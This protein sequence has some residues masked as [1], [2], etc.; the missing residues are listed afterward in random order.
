M[1][2]PRSSPGIEAAIAAFNQ[3][4]V[5]RQLITPYAVLT[6]ETLPGLYQ[7]G[8]SG[9]QIRREVIDQ[10]LEIPL[11]IG[12][13]RSQLPENRPRCIG[14][15]VPFSEHEW[16]QNLVKTM[17]A[18]SS[19]LGIEFEIIDVHQS[20]RDEIEMRRKEI[21]ACAA[22]LINP[23]DVILI[24]SGPLATFLAE[25]LREKENI[26]VITN[27]IDVFDVLRANSEIILILT[28]GAYRHTS[29]ALVGP[30][31]EGALRELRADKLFLS[32]AGVSLDFGLSHTNISEVTIKQA[33]IRSAREIILLADHTFFGQESVIQVAPPTAVHKLVTDD[34]L[35]ASARLELSKLGIEII[36]ANT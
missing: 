19:N 34:A 25:A 22:R 7:R 24:D 17:R 21:A 14:F 20:L 30:T 6:A 36:L 12:E 27:A 31:A 29:Q 8:E 18:Y 4:P 1:M 11:P 5:S 2:H 35:P 28:G 9:W 26:T 13:R 10:Q 3:R 32:A 16:Y 23:G 15:L 33:M